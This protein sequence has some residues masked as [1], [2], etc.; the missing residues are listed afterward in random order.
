L[1]KV[2]IPEA[3]AG[4]FE[5]SR[6]KAYY[7]GRGSGKSHSVAAALI[8]IGTQRPIRVG[9]FREVQK[10]IRDSVKKV[11][12]DKIA[13]MGLHGF[14]RSLETEI[15][16]ANGTVF[17]FAGLRGN[18][19]GIRSF[20]GLTHAWVE[21]AA[22][23]SQASWD[24]LIPTV[25]APGSEIWATWNP[26]DPRDPVDK[27]FRGKDGAPPGAIVRRVNYHDNPWF[28]EELELER[29]WDLQ[30]DPDKHAHIWLGEY[31][32]NS[33]ARVFRNWRV[34]AF[35]T[36]VDD[37]DKGTTSPMFYF[38][39]DWGFSVDPTVLVRC[40]VHGRTLYVDHE[41]YKVGCEI[42][43]TPA[44]FD[45]LVPGQPNMARKWPIRADSARPETISY[46]QRNGYPR[47]TPATKGAGSVEDGIEFL[48][49]FD[50]VVHP[51]CR[52]TIDELTHYAFKTDPL[53]NEVTPIL[54]DKKNHVID[55]LRYSVELL[56]RNNVAYVGSYR[57]G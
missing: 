12:D 23:V 29:Q 20:E 33:E 37:K 17:S 27:M 36:P 51:R 9:C 48:K 50:I 2:R 31:L 54:E 11:L 46:M 45:S 43:R 53:T 4:L 52:H 47:I 18:A 25:R 42:D 55:A 14:Y 22:T 32:R 38:G 49:S 28:P 24:T 10:S 26:R 8:A 16:G 15:R 34:E 19:D 5:P 7:G 1:S 57:M 6:Y 40:W 21:E 39:A 30:R 3:F 35:E 44:L 56:R 41:A 13:A